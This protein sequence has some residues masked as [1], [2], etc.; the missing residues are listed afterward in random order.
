MN[1]K[2][3]TVL[4]MLGATLL[5]IVLLGGIFLIGVLLTMFLGRKNPNVASIGIIVSFVAAI[6]LSMFLY[7]KILQWA[8]VKFD[9]ENKMDPIFSSRRKR[10]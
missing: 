9:L 2:T 7:S 10:K 1:K 3:F 8:M 6:A 5:N 4:F